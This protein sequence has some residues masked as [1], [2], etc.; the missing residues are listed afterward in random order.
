MQ[1]MQQPITPS[2]AGT[3]RRRWIALVFALVVLGVLF[4]AW[5][6]RRADIE[7]RSD[8]LLQA[9]MIGRSINAERVQLLTGT[10]ADEISPDYLRLKQQLAG[11]CSANPKFRFV[12]LMGRKADGAVFFFVDSEPQGSKDESPAGQIHVEA[13]ADLRHVFDTGTGMVEGPV[14]DR[15]GTWIT[16]LVPLTD[17]GSGKLIAVLGMDI[18]AREWKW[19][20]A[21]KSALPVA[22]GWFCILIALFALTIWRNARQMYRQKTR[23]HES[24]TYLKA[25]FERLAE[26]GRTF[27]WE[28][29]ADG[30][31]TYLSPV[32]EKMLGYRVEDVVGK[33]HFYDLHPEEGREAFRESCFA[34]FA[35]KM[36][37]KNL[38]NPVQTRDG[39]IVWLLT[40]GL[41]VLNPDGTL[42]GYSGSDTDITRTKQVREELLETNRQL[43]EAIARANEMAVKAEI[44]SIAKSEFLANMS[45]EI[46]TPMN[47]V[48]G[49]CGLLLDTEL[50][51]EQRRYAEIARSSA[52]SLL[53]IIS[54]I[55]DISK[56]E[57][58]KLDLEMMDFDLQ[59]LM[60]DF[61]VS[62]NPRATDKGL[63]WTCVIDPGVPV[64][65]RG[66]PGRLRQVL[67]NLA[68]NA[69]KFTGKG[70]VLV[71]VERVAGFTRRD[72]GN[73][74]VWGPVR[75]A[76]GRIEAHD[77]SSGGQPAEAGTTP[78]VL[79]DPGWVSLRF[80][81]QDTGIGI[82]EDKIGL[83]FDKFTQVDTSTTRQYG[84]TGLGL[85]ISKQLVLMMGGEIGVSSQPGKGSE[86]WFTVP[87]QMHS[88]GGAGYKQPSR[89]PFDAQARFTG[90]RARILVAEDNVT[91]QQV[92]MGML[93]KFGL[94]ADAVA[95]GHEALTALKTIPYDLVLMDVQMPEMDGLKTT[96]KIRE[97]EATRNMAAGTAGPATRDKRHHLPIVAMTAHALQDDRRKCLEAGM[98]D[99]VTKPVSPQML[100]SVLNKWLPEEPEGTEQAERKG[101]GAVVP[102]SAF[103]IYGSRRQE[104]ALPPVWDRA[105]ML[106]RLMGDEQLADQIM[107]DFLADMPRSIDELKGYLAAG[108]AVGAERKTHSIKGASANV[109]GEALY[110]VAFEM[111]IAAKAG[112]LG[113]IQMRLPELEE[114]FN[115]LEKR[116]KDCISR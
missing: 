27:I 63:E 82:P 43:E 103:A 102:D 75:P 12:Y 25:L 60:D 22:L 78:S 84:G 86:F 40:N 89:K 6:V 99:Y 95:D 20:V 11:V 101:P 74:W 45:H 2:A 53:G 70:E 9:R 3:S 51:E 85:A 35:S 107:A 97:W 111:E 59:E 83:L 46:R 67:T 93:R 87:F 1:M 30:R 116:S 77:M 106:D 69:V 26:Q 19:D 34:I 104:E 90:R 88:A 8:I 112:D 81:V 14:T 71:R 37:F 92:A 39:R 5:M 55:L 48:I 108:D 13:S 113:S 65:L 4:S 61:A 96:R 23:M 33:S 98:D 56:I 68:G 58:R 21:E 31:F 110:Q 28:V 41:P 115:Q 109:G 36:P 57:A 24:E 10:N 72:E 16:A 29:D 50:S 73:R 54:D 66:D 100:A 7:L 49:M 17:A 105:G 79:P 76:G 47:G 42:A 62:M 18:D 80:S 44:A 52:E 91:N 15:W 32:F 64:R 38:E 114:A 94:S